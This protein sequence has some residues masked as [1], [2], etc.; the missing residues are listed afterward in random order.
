MSSS[1][2]RRLVK[3]LFVW[4]LLA[5]T[6]GRATTEVSYWLWDQSQLPIYRTC[7]AAFEKQNP[8]IKINITQISWNDYWNAL[9]EAFVLGIGP[10]V[11]TNS[12]T[13]FPELIRFNRLLDL[14]PLIARDKVPTEI[15]FPGLVQVWSRDGKQYGFPKD[16]STVAIA[17]NKAM[18]EKA[19]VDP[20][21]LSNL[22]WNPKDGGSFGSLL[23]RLSLDANG[24][25]GLE[26]GFDP[27]NVKQYGLVIRGQPDG[28]GSL[29]WSELAA[30]DGFKFYDGPWAKRFYYDDPRLAQTI[31]WLADMELKKGFVIPAPAA[32]LTGARELLAAQRGALA[33]INSADIISCLESC[34]F[35]VGFVLP[36]EGPA[37]PKA[38]LINGLSDSIWAGTKHREEAWKWVKFLA[39]PEGQKIVGGFGVIFPAIP[40][41]AEIAQA[42]M[43]RKVIDVSFC[44]K[45][46]ADPKAVF[47]VPVSDRTREVLRITDAACAAIFFNGGNTGEALKAANEKVNALFD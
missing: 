28:F 34:R 12:L 7:A 32:L 10:D 23:A 35:D 39:S 26:A 4:A 36:P 3:M 40:E 21:S 38:M 42:T 11:I 30:S 43:A 44:L 47:L 46:A 5:G 41:A 2:I 1:F 22:T 18:L 27:K 20:N 15:Y 9:N 13:R 33:L 24:R 29:E 14:K 19:G 25:N 8:D 45:E 16:W 17:Y 31:Q 37:G 6:S